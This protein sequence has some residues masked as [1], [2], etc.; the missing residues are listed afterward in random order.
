MSELRQIQLPEGWDVKTL[1]DI[2]DIQNGY[3]FKS[4]DYSDSG[5][6]VIRISNVQ[7][8]EII[9]KKPSFLPIEAQ[10]IYSDFILN[11]NDILVSLTGDVGRVGRISEHLLPAVLNQRVGRFKKIDASSASHKFCVNIWQDRILQLLLH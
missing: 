5:L 4:K 2:C 6:R 10:D 7:K 9:D 3:A 1:G 8:G 11:K